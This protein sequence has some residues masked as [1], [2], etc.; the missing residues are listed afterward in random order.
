MKKTAVLAVI[1]AGLF[2]LTGCTKNYHLEC[3]AGDYVE[4]DS[5]CGYVDDAGRWQYFSWTKAGKTTYSPN[6]WE[7]PA[8]VEIEQ[9][10]PSKIKTKK[11]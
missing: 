4:H 2:A 8:G 7:P 3:D 6:G 1:L 10:S 11:H 9:D 5:D